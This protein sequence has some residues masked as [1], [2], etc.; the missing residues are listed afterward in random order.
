MARYDLG[1]QIGRGGICAVYRAFDTHLRREVAVKRLLPLEN[2]QLE[3]ADEGILSREVL[4]LAQLQHPNVVTVYEF[5]EDE[6]GPFAVLE[7]I[8]GESLKKVIDEG[9]L[10]Y[11]DF[12]EIVGQLIDPLISAMELNLLHRDIKPE[13]IMLSQLRSGRLQVKILDFGLAKI[14]CTPQ[15]QTV[16]LSG[17]F[18]GSVNYAAPEQFERR[19]LDQRTDLYSL[20][21]VLYFALTQQSPFK[22]GNCSETM[23]NHLAHR[24]ES[25]ERYRPD[26]PSSI[27]DFVM[28][29][30]ERD[31]CERPNDAIEA[32]QLFRK[33]VALENV[34]DR[35][36]TRAAKDKIKQAHHA[37]SFTQNE[38]AAES[39]REDTVPMAGAVGN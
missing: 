11:S 39:R 18:L 12:V 15:A 19:L 33:A 8:E 38:P 28:M 7:L 34:P 22:G 23:N 32:Y 27:C 13:N 6:N 30:I 3:E 20:G 21:C 37:P 35:K 10:S 14:T 26:L 31:P 24:V 25:L 16:D 1:E 2:T 17:S 29:L 5:D 4:A 9:A 36:L